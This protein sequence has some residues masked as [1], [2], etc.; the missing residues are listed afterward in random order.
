MLAVVIP[1]FV[2]EPEVADRPSTTSLAS[3]RDVVIGLASDWD[4]EM[5]LVENDFV[6]ICFVEMSVMLVD[7]ESKLFSSS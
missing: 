1:R 5:G 6:E 2:S 3:D 7:T 4:V